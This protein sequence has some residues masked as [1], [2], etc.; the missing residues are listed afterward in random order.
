MFG[1]VYFQRGEILQVANNAPPRQARPPAAATPEAQ[2]PQAAA[3]PAPAPAARQTT[4][5]PSESKPSPDAPSASQTA[6]AP[7]TPPAPDDS[8]ILSQNQKT[9]SP[10]SPENEAG[11]LAQIAPSAAPA[12]VAT[13]APRYWIEFGAYETGPY[14]DRLKQNLDQLGIDSSVNPV[15]GKHGVRYL[16]VRTSGDLDHAIAVAQIAKAKSALRITPLLHRAAAMSPA[17]TRALEA[18]A[19]PV[20][21]ATS[22]G[23]YWVQFGAFH[24]HENAQQLLSTLRESDIQAFVIETK[25]GGPDL[26]YRVRASNLSDR[27]QAERIAQQGNAALHTNDVFIGGA[28]RAATPGLHR[29]P[30]LR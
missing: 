27:A 23:P 12:N 2:T 20:S 4:Q 24:E 6:G 26:L 15:T 5:A 30:P 19:T 8:Q 13:A 16:R 18:T 7:A 29:R 14:G 21:S 1:A 25:N 22:S 17:P 9:K 10:P 28:N 11:R 3:P